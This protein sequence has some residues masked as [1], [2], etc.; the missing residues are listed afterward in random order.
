MGSVINSGEENILKG[1]FQN[2]SVNR[3]SVFTL[4]LATEASF[5]ETAV[6][7]DV[8][9]VTGTGYAPVSIAADAVDWT[10]TKIVDTWA[11]TSKECVFTC[12]SGNL[13]TANSIVLSA[14]I[15]GVDTLIAWS[16]LITPRT[17]YASDTLTTSVIIS[18]E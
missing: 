13:T 11:A 1:W 16:A 15:N 17:L 4:N 7:T 8:T 12:T 18:L 9:E 2:L 6:L 5:A 10:V 3:P 14:T